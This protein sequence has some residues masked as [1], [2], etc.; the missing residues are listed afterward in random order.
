VPELAPGFRFRA[1]STAADRI[2]FRFDHPYSGR[3][4]VW[5]APRSAGHKGYADT[6]YL[7][8]WYDVDEAYPEGAE[9]R[10]H[11]DTFL[12]EV[13]A[14]V[15]RSDSG[16]WVGGGEPGDTG[17]THARA[18]E[19]SGSGHIPA[20]ESS[21]PRHVR[22]G[23]S[24]ESGRARA[25]DGT[26][27]GTED[28]A[29]LA[30]RP[31]DQ[32]AAA[33]AFFAL[34]LS[35]ISLWKVVG[36]L[37]RILAGCG[38]AELA[39]V[40]A[41]V[42][43]GG[44]RLVL[45]P[46]APVKVG[47]VFPMLDEAL[48]L[49]GL[50]RYGAGGAVLVHLIFR[51][52]NVHLEELLRFNS[53]LALAVPLLGAAAVRRLFP[54]AGTAGFSALYLALTPLFLRDGNTE[55][56][57]VPG[58]FLVLIGLHLL[59]EFVDE[60]AWGWGAAAL[61]SLA[62]AASMRPE[63]VVLVIVLPAL[64]WRRTKERKRLA[65]V[66]VSL[67][68]LLVPGAMVVL[69]ATGRDLADGNLAVGR[70][71]P[72]F[73][74]RNLAVLN[75]LVAPGFFPLSTALLG[76]AGLGFAVRGRA[77]RGIALALAGITMG[78]LVFLAVDLNEESMLRLEVPAAMIW[79]VLAAVGSAA[80]VGRGRTVAARMGI[81]AGIVAAFVVSSVPGVGVLFEPTNSQEDSRVFHAAMERLPPGRVRLVVLTADDAPELAIKDPGAVGKEPP[82]GHVPVH[83]QLPLYRLRALRPDVQVVS[84]SRFRAGVERDS[85]TFFYLG[86]SCYAYRDAGGNEDWGVPSDPPP[87]LH[88][89]C[90]HV[91][92][93]YRVSPFF[94]ERVPNRMEVAPAFHWYPESL[95]G[96]TLG[97][98]ELE[99]ASP[100]GRPQDP[101]ASVGDACNRE[102]RILVVAGALDRAVDLLDRCERLFPDSLTVAEHLSSALYLRGTRQDDREDLEGAFHRLTRVAQG[103]LGR[104]QVLSRLGSIYFF[105]SKF[106][107]DAE[108]EAEL[109]ARLQ[110]DPDDIVGLYLKGL[111]LFYARRDYAAS[112]FFF[113]KVLER[114]Q[115]EPRVFVYLALDAFYRGRQE[116]AEVWIKR[117]VDLAPAIEDPDVYYVRSIIVR[118]RDLA[119]AGND[120]ERYLELTE[121]PD[122][123][124]HPTKQAWLRKELENLR[125]GRPSDWWRSR[126]PTEPW[127]EGGVR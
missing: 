35:V 120:I 127:V 1:V 55:S 48:R 102:A 84:V 101:W 68:L 73:V 2:R 20:G 15:R 121:G 47:M 56:L 91:L 99:A 95:K 106:R 51:F 75:V 111:F 72:G 94:L 122:R 31:V 85:R 82:P 30:G 7:T 67:C 65:V 70:L 79:S 19:S 112:E 33:V 87:S 119:Q 105:Y 41:A 100:S 26:N 103:D 108:M 98:L 116:E 107:T 4:D 34:L 83:R 81:G 38:R 54:V 39:V 58:F 3:L 44:I 125:A 45:V 114:K 10:G 52:L 86:A 110:A 12:E 24:S 123:V 64:L 77:G 92:A 21:G 126:E 37:R 53:M 109:D 59:L 117:G 90:R 62:A 57:L 17:G 88:P 104:P 16:E 63:L 69:G 115:D 14:V 28:R 49:E 118:T 22:P 18:G 97:L 60:G 27:P 61:P 6:D 25:G 11:L 9:A 43:A 93:R 5:I 89:A 23:E 50:P 46:L 8:I 74:L 78:W 76:L 32:A 36:P 66:A 40:L 13:V 113:L 96:M 29:W 42:A 80:L 124:R 71:N